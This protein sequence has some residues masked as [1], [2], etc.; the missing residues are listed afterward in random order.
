MGSAFESFDQSPLGAFIQS[1]L[2]ARGFAE[3][4]GQVGEIF[5]YIAGQISEHVTDNLDSDFVLPTFP[6]GHGPSSIL[7]LVQIDNV[8][9]G[10]Y[11]G[12]PAETALVRKHSPGGWTEY[13]NAS[14]GDCWSIIEHAGETYASITSS[15]ISGVYV[16]DPI[17]DSWSAVGSAPG[18]GQLASSSGVLWLFNATRD[19]VYWSDPNWVEEFTDPDNLDNIA[20]YGEWVG[21]NAVTN[22]L[23]TF[24][25]GGSHSDIDGS[26]TA[27]VS[28][29]STPGFVLWNGAAYIAGSDGTTNGVLRVTSNSISLDLET[30]TTE[31]VTGLAVTPDGLQLMITGDFAEIGG[32]TCDKIALWDGTTVTPFTGSFFDGQQKLACLVVLSTTVEP[33]IGTVA[34]TAIPATPYSKQ[35]SYALPGGKPTSWAVAAGPTGLTVSSVGLVSW[36]SPTSVGE[37]HTVT[38]EGTNAGGT[39]SE[40]WDLTVVEVAPIITAIADINNNTGGEFVFPTLDQGDP[41]ITWSGPVLPAGASINSSSGTVLWVGV[42]SPP[43]TLNF[44]IRATNAAGSDDELF[45]INWT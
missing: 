32:V 1:T 25:S 29:S 12:S 8:I 30:D 42:G 22:G 37:P 13:L 16:Y 43:Q 9:W 38:I 5:Y 24:T 15:S 41:V 14:N 31:V 44:V 39:A 26:T 33:L 28:F 40:S 11:Q 17:G 18:G 20:K 6:S 27:S 3:D 23:E 4:A 36:P 10:G 19:P 21:T 34:D 2:G 7:T 35:L 45:V